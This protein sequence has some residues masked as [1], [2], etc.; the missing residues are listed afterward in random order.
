M[1]VSIRQAGR[2]EDGRMEGTIKAKNSPPKYNLF[3]QLHGSDQ[4]SEVTSHLDQ[5]SQ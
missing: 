1:I 4:A 5:I 2:L 3:G